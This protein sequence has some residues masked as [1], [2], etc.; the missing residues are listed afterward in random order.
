MPKPK[1]EAPQPKASRSERTSRFLR[2]AHWLG[3][4]ALAGAAVVI[5]P[6]AA[7]LEIFSAVEVAHGGAWEAARRHFKKSGAKKS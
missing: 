4:V 1:A 5:P 3:A 2:N 7:G 6:A